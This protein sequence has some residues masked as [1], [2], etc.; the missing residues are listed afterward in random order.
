VPVA[1]YI[2]NGHF[3]FYSRFVNVAKGIICWI[4]Q[5]ERCEQDEETEKVSSS[6][7]QNSLID[8]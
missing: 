8:D 2:G 3:I 1:T 7:K 6:A 4:I 5:I